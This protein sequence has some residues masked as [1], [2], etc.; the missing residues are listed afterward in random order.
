MSTPLLDEIQ[1]LKKSVNSLLLD[2]R[3]DDLPSYEWILL[4]QLFRKII[5]EPELLDQIHYMQE[6]E[7]EQT[8]L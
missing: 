6:K 3:P 7:R 2:T 5:K 8:I 4:Q 1:F